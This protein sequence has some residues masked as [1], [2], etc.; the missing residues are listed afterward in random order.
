MPWDLPAPHTITVNVTAEDIDAYEHVN[1]SVYMKWLDRIA[2]DHS[3]AVGL[4]VER[5]LSLDRGMVV[6]RSVIAY[7]RPALRD[8]AVRIATWLIPN[9]RKVRITRRFQVI[10]V[11]DE[12]TLAR[13]EFLE[14]YTFKDEVLARYRELACV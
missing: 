7:L 13:A 11:A 3:A 6:S 14:R 2:W 9:S 8:D 4:P 10:R 1:N 5:C 12:A